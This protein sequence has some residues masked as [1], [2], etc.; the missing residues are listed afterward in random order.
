M[1]QLNPQLLY[2]TVR[3]N[4]IT[5]CGVLPAVIVM[6]TLRRLNQL[7]KIEITGYS[8]SADTTGDKS[9]VVGYC[10]MLLGG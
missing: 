3:N 8:T 10:G 1:L 5:M 2:E 6:E 7:S 4:R 9:S